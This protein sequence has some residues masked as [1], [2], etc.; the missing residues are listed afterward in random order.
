MED[1]KEVTLE[2]LAR[3]SSY[4]ASYL[5]RL[6]RETFDIPFTDYVNILRVNQAMKLLRETDLTA[7]EIGLEVGF[8]SRKH[9]YDM[10]RRHTGMT[11][12]AF[13]EET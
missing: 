10:F 5:S 4:N 6:F 1:V 8:H 3:V 7:E 2:E 13:R 9:F 12:G 11:P